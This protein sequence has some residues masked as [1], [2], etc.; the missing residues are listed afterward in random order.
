[1]LFTETYLETTNSKINADIVFNYSGNDLRDFNNKVKIDALI[2]AS[3]VSI[4][5]LK[6]LYNE[7]GGDNLIYVST[8]FKGTVNNFKL[9]NFNASFGSGFKVRGN[10]RFKEALR[11]GYKF[12][13]SGVTDELTSD[14]RQLK[15]LMPNVIGKNLPTELKKI[16][17]FKMSGSTL[18]TKDVLDLAIDIKSKMGMAS[19]DLEL[20]NI[21]NIDDATYDG[22]VNV[23]D[24]ELGKM[25]D[26]PLFGKL[27]FE[28]EVRGEGFKL[29][30]INTSLIGVVSKQEYKGY[31]YT[32]A[33]VDGVLRNKLFNGSLQLDDPNINFDFTGLADFSKDIYEFDFNAKIEKL[34]LKTLH[35]F[36]RDSISIVKGDI[37]IDLKGNSLDDVV[38]SASIVNGSYTNE[39]DSHD[40]QKFYLKSERKELVR[41]LTFNSPD[42]ID[43]KM[44]GVFRFSDLSTM[45]QNSIGS[46]MT[47]YDALEI[48]SNRFIEFDFKIFSPILPVL[49]PD[50]SM[51]SSALLKGKI[52]AENNE[53]KML[54]S[55]PKLKFKNTLIDSISLKVDNKNPSLSTNLS[56]KE[57]KSSGYTMRGLNLYN[58]KINDTLYFRSDF[59]GGVN[60]EERFGLVF[61]YTIDK[62]KKSILGIL[63][64]KILFKKKEWIL[65]PSGNKNNKL[66]FDLEKEEFEIRE[67]ELVTENQEIKFD[68]VIRD[69]T[70][71]N[72]NMYFD[73]V[74]LGA[75]MPKIDSLSLE[76]TLNGYLNFKQE[77][78]VYNPLGNLNIKDFVINESLQGDL[79]MDVNAVDSYEKYQVDIS[80]INDSLK[81]FDAFGYIDIGPSTPL[82]DLDVKL[83]GFYLN[84]F[85]PLGKNVLSHLRGEANGEFKVTGDLSNPDMDGK[86]DLKNAGFT[87]PYLNVDYDLIKSPSIKLEKQR[88]K[89]EN[90]VLKDTRYNTKGDINGEIEH[91]FYKNWELDLNLSSDRLLILDT[92]DVENVSYYGTG[93]IDGLSRISGTT[94]NLRIDVK[95]KT[96]AGTKFIIPLNDVKASENSKLIHFKSEYK[97]DFD[98]TILNNDFLLEKFQGLSLNFDIDITPEASAEI[99]IDRVSGSSLKGNGSGNLFI[100]IDTKG[101]F[102]MFGDYLIDKGFYN[103]IYGGLINKPFRI[104]RGGLISWDGDPMD[105]HLNI[106]AIHE[107][108]ANPKI[109]LTDLNTNRKIQVDLITDISGS[110]FNSKED[111]S[112][113]IPN[114]SSTVASELSFVLNTGDEN[115]RF[116][117]FFSLLTLKS[118]YNDDDAVSSAGDFVSG[119]TS[120]IISGALSDIFNEDGDKFQID[121]GYTSGDASDIEEQKIDNQVDISLKTQINDKILIDGNLAVPVGTSSQSNVIGEVKVEF[122]VDDDGR[123]R[124]TVFNRQNEVQYAQ[125]EE[126]YTQGV[127]LVYQIDFSTVKEMFSR[128]RPRKKKR[129]TFEDLDMEQFS[130][131]LILVV[132]SIL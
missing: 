62:S 101:K 60:N 26:N 40:F 128:G 14:Y 17:S 54:V 10:Y 106:R 8:A 2:D 42:I 121:L 34:D 3:Q 115:A 127:G 112:I 57:I 51:K 111:F 64:S 18:V 49:V 78:G 93:F 88:F 19:L 108:K 44:K 94:N 66:M 5:D 84:A 91:S 28:G 81:Q 58:K 32:G 20:T 53:L 41:T 61:Y 9:S 109:L 35:L 104:E 16:G 105:A 30:N 56:V 99:V 59:T 73:N 110:L 113:V 97:D 126:G 98:N 24:F 38:G 130:E 123:L 92:E 67:I 80:L 33:R 89:F 103:F 76:G 50:I 47:N 6:K 120:D 23:T 90:L 74:N 55:A 116:R 68:G 1:M 22:Y 46:M 87:F 25:I 117:Q 125:E 72:L 102:N 114:S 83:N 52:I 39:F 124:Y 75:V 70:Y 95:A 129:N 122:L 13:V 107:V 86:I 12:S 43:G 131:D 4:L 79:N 31:S 100:E 85:S 96:L 36:E 7:F 29:E 45:L 11:K 132:P 119:T 15:R 65:N 27:S 48:E 77:K 118:F 63:E 71:K 37:D 82:I 21:D 69:S